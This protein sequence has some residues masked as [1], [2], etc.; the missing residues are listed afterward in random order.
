MIQPPGGFSLAFEGF[1][2]SGE[3]LREALTSTAWERFPAAL[4]SDVGDMQGGTTKEGIHMGVM[5]GTVDLVQRGYAGTY[6]RDGVLHFDPR[7]PPRLEALSFPMQFQGTPLLVS[8]ADGQLTLSADPE[9]A[10]R[11]IM[12]CVGDEVRELGAGEPCVFAI[13]RPDPV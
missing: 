8:L 1:D 11:P 12:A 2:P 3:G 6:I 10:T 9:A 5:S 4:E 7:L 13:G